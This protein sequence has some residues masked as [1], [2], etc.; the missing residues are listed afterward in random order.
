MT[1]D[2]NEKNE[3]VGEIRLESSSKK[4]LKSMSK[5]KNNKI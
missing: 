3:R 4:V 5:K 1:D 2:I